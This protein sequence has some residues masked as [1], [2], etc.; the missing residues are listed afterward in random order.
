LKLTIINDHYFRKLPDELLQKIKDVATGYDVTE[1]EQEGITVNDLIDSDIV[2]GRIPPHLLIGL[3]NLKWQHLASAGAN[4]LMDRALYANKSMVLTKSSGTFGIPMAEHIIGMMIALGRDFGHYYK[5]QFEGEWD[6]YWPTLLDIE[7]STV[8]IIGLG[9]IGTEVSKHLSGFGCRL[10]GMRKNISK[11]HDIINDVRS[12]SQLHET[13]PEV[14]Y[15]IICTPGTA[16]TENLFGHYEFELMKST[17]IIVNVG[18]GMIIDSD[19]LAEAL[20]ER[21]IHGAGLDVTEPEPLTKGHP[22]WSARNVLITP[23][24]SAATN[25][26]TKRRARVFIK[27]LKRYL[28]G[29]DMYNLVDFDAGY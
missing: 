20:N 3:P 24:V 11:H 1:V 28:A 22:L 5:K 25:V 17:A 27:L 13:L 18:R 2:F 12:V 15:V 29:D 16:E 26:T 19:A 21:K 6:S 9:D 14:D 8:L 7:G 10:I 23:H 4:G